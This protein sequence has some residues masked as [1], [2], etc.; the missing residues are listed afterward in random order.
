[1][2]DE[3]YK[4]KTHLINETILNKNVNHNLKFI[5]NYII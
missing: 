3:D 2:K 5:L 4:L 1:M